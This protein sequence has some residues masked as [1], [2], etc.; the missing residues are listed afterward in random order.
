MELRKDVKNMKR[1]VRRGVFETNSSS[2]HSITMCSS[3]EYQ[4]W[5]D[6][7]LLYW[8]DKKKF[9]VREDIIEEMQDIS[10][11]EDTNWEDE[12]EVN[13]VFSDKGVETYEEF[14]DEDWYETFVDSYTTPNGEKVVAF[15]YYGHD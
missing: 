12:D 1:Q 9:G 7:K 14:F 3:E 10:W 8:R 5:I 2:V 13:D 6:G 11:L 15:G 4:K